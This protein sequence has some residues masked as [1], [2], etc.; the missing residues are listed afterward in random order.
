MTPTTWGAKRMPNAVTIPVAKQQKG[1]NLG[2][3]L[4]GVPVVLLFQPRGEGRDKSV[5]K[6][7]FSE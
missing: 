7:A 4:P 2:H 6:R 5:G 3:E 1:E